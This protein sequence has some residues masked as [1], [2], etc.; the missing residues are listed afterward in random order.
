MRR[1][2]RAARGPAR[3]AGPWFREGWEASPRAS[4]PARWRRLA[5]PVSPRPRCVRGRLRDPAV[6]EPAGPA[7]RTQGATRQPPQTQALP[8]FFRPRWKPFH[9]HTD[10]SKWRHSRGSSRRPVGRQSRGTPWAA[11]LLAYWPVWRGCLSVHCFVRFEPLPGKAMEFREELLRVVEAT[12]AEIG[13]FAIRVFEALREPLVFAI[14]SEWVDEAA[15]ELHAQLPH[16]VRFLGA[17]GKLLSHPVQGL[18][19]REIGG[20]AGPGAAG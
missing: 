14:H 9:Q 15:F 4:A 11:L 18:R 7:R 19:S 2:G 6:R 13:C 8:R 17:A 12:R 5:S 1:P 16:T 3:E 10:D 20:G